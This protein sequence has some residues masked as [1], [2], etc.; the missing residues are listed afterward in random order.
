VGQA[1]GKVEAIG[2]ALNAAHA[3][4]AAPTTGIAAAGQ[5]EVSAAIAELFSAE[6]QAYQ[7]LSAE[8]SAFHEQFVQTLNAGAA[9]YV[10]TE[11][12]N[13]QAFTGHATSAASTVETPPQAVQSEISSS[14]SSDE[15]KLIQLVA[16][17][18]EQQKAAQLNQDIYSSVRSD[19]QTVAQL[20]QEQLLVQKQAA[21][22]AQKARVS[23]AIA[24]AAGVADVSRV[25]GV[26]ILHAPP[27]LPTPVFVPQPK[28]F[29]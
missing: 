1:A 24:I 28:S 16:Q 9:S 23:A 19:E 8:A 15:Q 14:V 17:L 18:N 11:A 26:T 25:S 20:Q 29:G 4:A 7:A 10:G 6:G 5:D 2:S 3:A 21:L 12:A 13:V 22:D 27:P